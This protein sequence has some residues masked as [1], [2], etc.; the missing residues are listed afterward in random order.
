MADLAASIEHAG[1][2]GDTVYIKDHNSELMNRYL[3]VEYEV[4]G[5]PGMEGS[6]ESDED[7]DKPAIKESELKDAYG[8]MAEACKGLNYDTMELILDSLKDYKLPEKDKENIRKIKEYLKM[9]D[10]ENIGKITE[11]EL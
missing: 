10:W 9:L 11:S 6:E 3:L 1:S 7:G 8:S 4:A 5:V 2:I